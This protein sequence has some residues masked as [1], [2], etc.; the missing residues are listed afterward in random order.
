MLNEED[1]LAAVGEEGFTR[2]VAAFYRQIPGDEI[3]GPM[4]RLADA[5]T[6]GTEAER[7]AA[8]EARLRD[9]LIF[10]FGGSTRYIE[11]R[12]HP[13]LRMRHFK[14]DVDQAARDRWVMLMDNALDETSLPPD[15]T[16]TLRTFFRDVASFLIN[17]PAAKR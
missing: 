14:F 13:A 7:L 8:A 3:L 12:G 15:A 1:V 6:P 10:R 11:R 17:R 16:E 9:F 2:L 5:A 4:Y